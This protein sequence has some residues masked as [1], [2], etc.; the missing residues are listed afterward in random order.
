MNIIDKALNIFA[1]GIAA[2]RE[3]ARTEVVRQQAVR[4]VT[5]SLI[6]GVGSNGRGYGK[7]GASTTKS[8]ML[9]WKTPVGD[10]DT[11]IHQNVPKLRERARDLHMGSDIVA[12]AHKGLRTNIVG[13]GLRLNPAFDASYLG[14][15]KEHAETLRSSIQREW[16]LWADTTKCDAAGLNDFYELQGLAF[17]STLMSGDV[18]ALMPSKPRPWSVYDLKVNLIEADR[19]ATPPDKVNIDRERIQSGVEVDADGMVVAYHFSNRH[20]GAGGYSLSGSNE[21]VRVNKYG[22]RTGRVNVLHLFEA[23][24]PGQRRGIPVI[25]PIIE[26]L[27]QL[28][29]YTNAELAAAVITSMYTVFITTPADDEGGTPFDG[30]GMDDEDL[31]GAEDVPGATGD[32]IKLGQG[33]I[34]RTDPGEDVKFA[35]PTRPNPN[36]EAFVRAMLKQI[37]AA[38]ELPYEILTKQFTSSYSA[39]RGALLEAW[40]MYRMRRAWLSKTFCQPIY[41]EW[42]VE[43]VSKGRI[44]APG[45]FDDPAI[46]AAY[47]KAE[48]HGPSQG[49]LDPTKEVQA[50]VMRMDN[51]LSTG[52]RE[53][54][55]INGGSWEDNVQQRAYEQT[56]LKKLGLVQAAPTVVTPSEPSNEGDEDNDDEEG[57]EQN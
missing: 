28:S 56:R 47:T 20:P 7:H 16:A 55:E 2:K 35:D 4:K 34:M 50:A 26:S 32:E 3:Q 48:W 19:C 21:W 29:Q 53:T 30:V 1:P 46:F 54:A 6:G 44:D 9:F 15:T 24:R 37:A 27:K 49:L 57:G 8:S 22:K 33:A 40:K 39:S 52:T 13:T 12:A 43:A 5:N 38:L 18:F 17:I 41:E 45:I 31:D 23:E 51:N 36:Y 25:A 11:D 14:L 42:F 10:A